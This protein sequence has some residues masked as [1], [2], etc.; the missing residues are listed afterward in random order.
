MTTTEDH[1]R[2]VGATAVH[3]VGVEGTIEAIGD[4]TITIDGITLPTVCSGTVRL[5]SMHW[6]ADQV[7]QDHEGYVPEDDYN[8]SERENRRYQDGI[9]K[10]HEENH[11]GAFTICLHEVCRTVNDRR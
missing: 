7:E 1:P 9:V 8:A 5:I 6:P 4:D 3:L 10:L 2:V 11:P